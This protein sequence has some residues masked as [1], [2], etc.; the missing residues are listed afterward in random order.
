MFTYD[1]INN[2][3]ELLMRDIRG[4]IINDMIE[5]LNAVN[6]EII[7]NINI[8]SGYAKNTYM[9]ISVLCKAAAIGANVEEKKLILEISKSCLDAYLRLQ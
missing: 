8:T 5:S 1:V 7:N 2:C 9:K 3:I 6:A 4:D